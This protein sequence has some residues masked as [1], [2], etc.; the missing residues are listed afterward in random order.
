MLTN[1]SKN[2]ST[3]NSRSKGNASYLQGS[4]TELDSYLESYNDK[5]LYELLHIYE[6]TILGTSHLAS[7]LQD[8]HLFLDIHIQFNCPVEM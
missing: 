7:S 5:Y 1:A 3:I 6:S 2:L 8:E 4:N